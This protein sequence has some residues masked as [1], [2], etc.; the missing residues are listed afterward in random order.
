MLRAGRERSARRYWAFRVAFCWWRVRMRV[1]C[2]V[3]EG[4]RLLGAF[5][6]EFG[7]LL[8]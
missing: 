6:D 3:L 1:S 2:S 5:R 4:V 8:K 7:N